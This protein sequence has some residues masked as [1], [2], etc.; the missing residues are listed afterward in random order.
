MIHCIT[1]NLSVKIKKKATLKVLRKLFAFCLPFACFVE[2]LIMS[3]IEQL[4]H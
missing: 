4:K 2:L 1:L 3:L